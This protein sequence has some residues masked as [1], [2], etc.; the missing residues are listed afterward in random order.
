MITLPTLFIRLSKTV[1][2]LNLSGYENKNA[3]YFKAD[4]ALRHV[5][6]EFQQ[7]LFLGK[8]PYVRYL[9]R[10]LV[11]PGGGILLRL[12]CAGRES[13][14]LSFRVADDSSRNSSFGSPQ[15][16]LSCRI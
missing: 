12:R 15:L 10:G 16:R 11:V 8:P 6:G 2:L 1:L 7:F 4:T 14:R 13:F 9:C 5:L 3:K